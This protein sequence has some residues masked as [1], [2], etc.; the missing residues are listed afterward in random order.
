MFFPLRYCLTIM[1]VSRSTTQSWKYCRS[2][3]RFGCDR[4][5]PINLIVYVVVFVCMQVRLKTYRKRKAYLEGMLAAESAKLESQARFIMEI[6][7]KKL[8][9]SK[10]VHTSC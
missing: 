7:E 10:P 5:L 2:F 3:T 6:I 1:A 4:V 8:V 9:I